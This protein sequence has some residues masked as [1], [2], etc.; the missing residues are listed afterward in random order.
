MAIKKNA[1]KCILFCAGEFDA[2]SML[3]TAGCDELNADGNIVIAVDGG[4][5]YCRQL[6]LV[7]DI[8][9]GD[10]DSASLEDRKYSDNAEDEF[11]VVRLPKEK[12]DTDTVAAIRQGLELGCKE[13][14]LYGA[15]GGRIDHYF[16]NIQAL[17]LIKHKGGNG[18]IVG[19]DFDIF[20][21]ENETFTLK[22]RDKG[23]VSL[24]VLGDKAENVTIKGLYYEVENVEL[25]ND[26]PI[27]VSNEFC[28]KEA[29]ISVGN[30]ALVCMVG[31][32]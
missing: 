1:E 14:V 13:F 21:I 12:D 23:T 32:V 11:E 25:T 15:T 6:K 9:I 30:G 29:V 10:F 22:A 31:K 27:G 19:R 28:G 3:L 20:V 24:F 16:A 4:L 8:I 26:Y 2:D 18:L 7:P 17:L 5:S